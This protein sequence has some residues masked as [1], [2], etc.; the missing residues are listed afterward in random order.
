LQPNFFFRQHF[1]AF[2][3]I[4]QHFA[5]FYSIFQHFSAFYSIS[6]ATTP[7]HEPSRSLLKHTSCHL[8]TD[9]LK[10]ENSTLPK[11]A[12]FEGG[13]LNLAKVGKV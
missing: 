7:T 1:T 9:L 12:R 10:V 8:P 13:K 5:A 3:S 11:L 2:Y 6:F 4:L